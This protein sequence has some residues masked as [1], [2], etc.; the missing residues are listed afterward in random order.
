MTEN[1]DFVRNISFN[2]CFREVNSTRARYRILCGGAGSGKSYNTA[3]DFILKL[4]DRRYA[5]A[6]LMVVR[7]T[8]SAGRLSTFAELCGAVKRIFGEDAD[9]F[10]RIKQDPMELVSVVTGNS[11]IFRGMK[12]ASQRERVKSVSFPKG[13]LTWI[14]CEEATELDSMDLD[15]LDDRLRGELC[16]LNP[17]LYYQITLT[18][19]PT[20]A[21]HWL[22]KRFFDSAPSEDV[23]I[24]RSVFGDN[25]FIDEDY[26]ARMERRREQDPEGYQVYGLGEWGGGKDGLI[27]PHFTVAGVDRDCFERSCLAQD[28]GYNH[29][30]CILEVGSRDGDILVAR[31]LYCK[32]LDTGEIIRK[33]EEQMFP[34]ELMMYCDAAEPDRIKTWRKAG[35]R[36]VPVKKGAGSVSAQIDFL[37]S[38]RLIVDPSCVNLIRE[39]EG[40]MWMRDPVSG[41][42]TDIPQATE[43]D[44]IA[45]LRYSTGHFREKIRTVGKGILGL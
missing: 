2:P 28:F 33:S 6:N 42:F 11:V 9:R 13:K 15:I 7:K 31:E 8:E 21:S 18:F 12:D 34:K 16:E 17:R 35:Y 29:A 38:R 26:A 25:R 20:S 14:W 19:N 41:D 10:W 23:F 40:W 39:L 27:L 36:A 3:Q 45:A 30:N 24:H 4:S 37:K 22:K 43:D 5:G 32:G 44:A 1:R